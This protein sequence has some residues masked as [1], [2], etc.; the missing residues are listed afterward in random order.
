VEPLLAAQS[1][2]SLLAWSKQIGYT[3]AS[4][5]SHG[6]TTILV[7]LVDR[8]SGVR[9][10]YIYVYRMSPEP[11]AKEWHLVLFRPTDTEVVVQVTNGRMVFLTKA[12]DVILEQPLDAVGPLGEQVRE[13]LR[14]RGEK[15][16]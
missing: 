7:L 8:G 15:P 6:N 9:L 13:K 3:R 14:K 16:K 4:E 12:G 5:Y 2:E 10:D 11:K 1:K